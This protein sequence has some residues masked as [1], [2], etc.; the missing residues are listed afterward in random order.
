MELNSEV[1]ISLS[2]LE[3]YVTVKWSNWLQY[4]FPFILQRFNLILTDSNG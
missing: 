1:D 4:I 3:N 2:G